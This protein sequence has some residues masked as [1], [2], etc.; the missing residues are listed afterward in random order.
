MGPRGNPRQG[1]G[2]LQ[3]EAGAG[4]RATSH[5][6]PL[7]GRGI[8]V[9]RPAHQAEHLASLIRAAGGEA[10][11]FPVI[12]IRDV[13]NPAPLLALI[14]RLETFDI[15]IFISPN[16]VN[17]AMSLISS[18]RALPPT[19]AVAAVGS[20]SGRELARCGVEGVIVP[21]GR[22]DSE[23]LLESPLL[24]RAAGK[25]VVIFRGEGGRELLGE[26]LKARGAA[27]EYAECYR[28]A[29]AELDPA[30]LLDAWTRR[31]L[32]AITVTSSEGLRN[33]WELVGEAGQP[34][35]ARTPLFVPQPR[36]AQ[37]AREQGFATVLTTEPGDEG[38][39]AGLVDYFGT[40]R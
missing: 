11:L 22:A 14:D 17:K 32:A 4:K 9:T 18:R 21:A 36:I 39:V 25:R 10:I 3:R 16:A 5:A 15:A 33:L 12:E 24:G 2:A 1:S 38:L 20:A 8:V 26:T 40:A 34:P 37:N 13:E 28:R 31:R 6:G 29:R 23:G 19:L 35:L 30:P 7:S 27:V